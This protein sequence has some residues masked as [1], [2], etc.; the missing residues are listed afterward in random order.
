[1]VHEYYNYKIQ[2]LLE[3]AT[4]AAEM[5]FILDDYYGAIGY[6]RQEVCEDR[7][8]YLMPIWETVDA[9]WNVGIEPEYDPIKTEV[10][11]MRKFRYES[12][13]LNIYHIHLGI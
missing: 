6:R 11:T 1:M 13:L 12:K 10:V 8:T 2:K 9:R 5:T 4:L 3:I 7:H